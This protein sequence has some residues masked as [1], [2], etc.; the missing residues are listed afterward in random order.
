MVPVLA[1]RGSPVAAAG[2]A[3]VLGLLGALLVF[4]IAAFAFGE[5]AQRAP[6]RGLVLGSLIGGWAL[7]TWLIAWRTSRLHVVLSRGLLL[8]AVQ[9]MTLA[10]QVGTVPPEQLPRAGTLLGGVLG[11]FPLRLPDESEALLIAA[12]CLVAALALAAL[13]SALGLTDQ[14]PARE[15]AAG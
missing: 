5:P 15:D 8:G 1:R 4:A 2:L 7:S 12:L 14:P 6:A 9:W 11:G 13:R 3:A 10:L